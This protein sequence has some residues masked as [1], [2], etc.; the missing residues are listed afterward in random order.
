MRSWLCWGFRW[1]HIVLLTE[2]PTLRESKVH[3]HNEEGRQPLEQAY[4]P[5]AAESSTDPLEAERALWRQFTQQR[6]WFNAKRAV[7]VGKQTRKSEVAELQAKAHTLNQD[8]A[9][10]RNEVIIPLT[11]DEARQALEAINAGALQLTPRHDGDG[12]FVADQ[13]WAQVHSGLDE[14]ASVVGRAIE[15]LNAQRPGAL[16]ATMLH[17][18]CFLQWRVGEY[19]KAITT[20]DSRSTGRSCHR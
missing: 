15:A 12:Q 20:I 18:E 9:P 13:L 10:Y 6:L 4:R 1:T 8:C 14:L 19:G 7:I 17:I 2:S 11:I 3:G 16:Q 5:P